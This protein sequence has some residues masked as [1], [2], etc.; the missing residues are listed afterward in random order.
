MSQYNILV[1]RLQNELSKIQTA[2]QSATSQANKART[3]GDSDYLQAAALSL[4]NFYT[5]VERIFEE[6]AKE[7]DGQ[8]PTGAS[9][10]QKLL[11]QMGLEIPNTRPLGMRIK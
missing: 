3:T 10:Y 2:V 8:V 5:G 11:E 9:S 7:L 4:Q 6:V 1:A